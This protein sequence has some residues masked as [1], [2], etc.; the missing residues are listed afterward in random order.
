[1]VKSS[2]VVPK[3][4]QSYVLFHLSNGEKLRDVPKGM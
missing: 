3:G 1:M 4:M 2:E